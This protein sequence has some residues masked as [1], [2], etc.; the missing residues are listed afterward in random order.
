MAGAMQEQCGGG[1]PA[2]CLSSLFKPPSPAAERPEAMT[3]DTD[4]YQGKDWFTIDEDLAMVYFLLDQ[5]EALAEAD[6]D[7]PDVTRKR[8]ADIF[9]LVLQAKRR[10]RAVD[11]RRS[12]QAP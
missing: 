10:L 5:I 4:A 8:L 3:D 1:Y 7:P 11:S 6:D 2:A 12:G 9:P